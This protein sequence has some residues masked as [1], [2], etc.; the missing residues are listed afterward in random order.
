MVTRIKALF[1]LNGYRAVTKQDAA[2]T[3]IDAKKIRR[4]ESLRIF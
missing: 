3:K 2:K 4:R 1:A